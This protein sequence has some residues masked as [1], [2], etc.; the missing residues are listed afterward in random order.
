MKHADDAPPRRWVALTALLPI[1]LLVVYVVRGF[2]ASSAA[3]RGT[4][5]AAASAELPPGACA[6]PGEGDARARLAVVII[7]SLRYETATDPAIMPFLS[8]LQERSLHG[9]MKPCLSQLSLLCMRTMF[10]GREPLLVTGLT[11]FTGMQVEAP[12]LV[13]QLAARGARA[14]MV[15][16]GPLVSLYRPALVEAHDFDDRPD[17]RV[18]RDDYGRALAL[19]WAADPSLDVIVALVID[20]DGTAHREGIHT[21]RYAAKFREA[22][23]TVRE[24]EAR[25]GP[26]DTLFVLGDHGHDPEGHHS[27]G[28]D[29][30]TAYFAR[31]PV[32][33]P[34]QRLDTDMETTRFLL[35]VATCAPVSA[36]YDGQTPL[37]ALSVPDAYR[38]AMRGL[39][40]RLPPRGSGEAE[41]GL[42]ALLR[43][44][45]IGVLVLAYL[46]L[47][48]RAGGDARGPRATSLARPVV[49]N[50]ALLGLG[51]ITSPAAGLWAAAAAN[52]LLL[53]LGG[54]AGL[55]PALRAGSL[56]RLAWL[57]L[58]LQV[59]AGAAAHRYLIPLQDHVNA[60]W[61]ACFAVGLA[62]AAL[63]AAGPLS[64]VIG[65]GYGLATGWAAWG[66]T[67]FGLFHGPYYYG[68]ARNLL[69]GVTWLVA[70]AA[71]ARLVR[72]RALLRA[73][74]LALVPLIPLHLPLMKEWKLRYMMLDDGMSR[75]ALLGAAA[76][77]TA[78]AVLLTPD[79]A[80]WR[81]ALPLLAAFVALGL[82]TQMPHGMV[83]AGVL[84]FLSYQGYCACARALA[85]T[86]GARPSAR[87]LAPA[88]QVS[89]AF[90]L[91]FVLFR[92]VRF[93]NVSFEFVLPIVPVG[94]GETFTAMIAVPLVLARHC[95]P[96]ALLL[97][98]AERPGAPALHLLFFKLAS[99][100]AFLAGMEIA[101]ASA[102]ILF[103]RLLT[104]ELTLLAYLYAAVVVTAALA[105]GRAPPRRGGSELAGLT[106]GADPA[107]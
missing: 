5:E 19:S 31:G 104:Q 94:R 82:A 106:S 21:A 32:F 59:V 38:A 85:A 53:L 15:A 87:W 63:T 23:E 50:V 78:I 36:G 11:N 9:R 22:D 44:L 46:G 37:D 74:I 101:G 60:T 65:E 75:P 64:R 6:F 81:R 18:E 56:D 16:D 88:G 54:R 84:L 26:R 92:G 80:P 66:L 39:I 34:G 51:A 83:L 3:D 68:A 62:L 47:I 10:E 98:S 86:P 7:D 100:T 90:M 107:V 33:P 20:T 70:A 49:L 93:A 103:A 4:A 55:P 42:A 102:A 12:N 30:P 73:A 97:A 45:P 27:T 52:V 13:A 29:A 77:L 24:I 14:A 48:R 72:D 2:A 89:Y 43:W 91:F 76:A 67:L 25:L 69:F 41:G 57:A 96:I 17:P 1:L 58:A 61:Q 105:L 8:S 99:M 40:A 95:G 35:G 71:G 79:R 28:I